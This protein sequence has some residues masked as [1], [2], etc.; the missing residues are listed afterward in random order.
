MPQIHPQTIPL[1]GT[2]VLPVAI[3]PL[4][5]GFGSVPVGATS[6]AL[7][8]TVTNNT[9]STT[10]LTYSSTPDFT[11]TAGASNGCGSSLAANAACTIAV[12]FVPLQKGSV[13]GSLTVSGAT[14]T[15]SMT[16]NGSGS[17]SPILQFSPASSSF[18]DQATE[19]ASAPK[20][21]TV[22]N[23]SALPV[24]LNSV[25]A[26]GD[27][28]ATPSGASPCGG[29]LAAHGTCTFSVSFTP[30]STGVIRGGVAVANS[31]AISPLVYDVTGT[32][33]QPVVLSPTTLSFPAQN[34]GVTSS[35]QTLTLKNT[36]T[37]TLSMT[38]VAASGDFTAQPGGPAPCGPSVAANS[39]CTLV[40]TFT[41]TK[42]GTIKGAVTVNHTAPGSPQN[43][44][45]TGTGQ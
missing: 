13:W 7:T 37:V 34:T 25:T 24:T 3:T 15:V 1:S 20:T 36:Q 38:G 32:G 42:T 5:L 26:F 23:K 44:A 6:A 27:F 29:S 45:V 40:V 43:V 41:P 17:T 31:G 28:S 9:S 22:T 2:G 14:Q 39:S 16:G 4:T 33:V 18:G 30:L 21:V 19:V 10:S 12:S 8:V 11:A 35:P